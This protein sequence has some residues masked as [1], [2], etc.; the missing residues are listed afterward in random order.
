LSNEL[1][2]RVKGPNLRAVVAFGENAQ[3][4]VS[5]CDG[6]GDLS[7][8]DVPHPSSH[9]RWRLADSWRE[10]VEELRRI[11]PPDADGDPSVPNYGDEHREEDYAR[12][13]YRDLPFGVPAWLGDDSWRRRMNPPRWSSLVRPDEDDRHTLIWYAP[14]S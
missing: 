8:F 7:V 13:P 2:D 10:A 14:W 6:K 11:V 4:A 5:L 12:V 1:F 3:V 9:D